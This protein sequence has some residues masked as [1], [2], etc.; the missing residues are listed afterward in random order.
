VPVGQQT[1]RSV[2]EGLAMTV[3]WVVLGIGAGVLLALVLLYNGLVVKRN[4]VDNV[5][6]STDAL[7]KKRYDLVPNLVAT[8]E[9]YAEHERQ[10]LE[11]IT[12]LRA[13]ARSGNL[14]P[15]DEIR[16]NN[17]LSQALFN[18][19][20]VAENY[21]ELKADTNFMHLQRTLNELE[22]QISA[23]RRA[24][25]A[26]VTDYNNAVMTFPGN[27]VAGMFKFHTRRLFEALSVERTRPDVGE[28]Q[29]EGSA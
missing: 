20:G 22:E 14:A 29:S 11:R 7:L 21:P 15:D 25:N 1:H 16:L 27:L 28:P 2:G 26:A 17:Q 12:E 4:R 9:G 18:V 10:T 3:L 8:V 23:A 24:Y 13:E 5:F 19:I 6:A